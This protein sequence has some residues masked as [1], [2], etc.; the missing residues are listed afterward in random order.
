VAFCLSVLALTIGSRSLSKKLGDLT[1]ADRLARF[2]APGSFVLMV[3]VIVTGSDVVL[4]VLI[5]FIGV[6]WLGSTVQH[7][8]SRPSL[9]S[10]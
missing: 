1:F 10:S 9:T 4:G 2:R 8:F 7:A 5:G 6:M 3:W